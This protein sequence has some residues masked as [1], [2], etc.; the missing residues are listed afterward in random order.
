M[1]SQL[2]VETAALTSTPK[3]AFAENN[4]KLNKVSNINV[5]IFLLRFVC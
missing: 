4:D 3:V 2:E 1:H 5:L